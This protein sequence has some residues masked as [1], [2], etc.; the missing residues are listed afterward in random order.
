[1]DDIL[2]NLVVVIILLSNIRLL[3]TSRIPVMIVSVAIQGWVIGSLPLVLHW[4]R[5]QLT[6]V[7]ITL[8]TVTIKGV[9]LPRLLN[10]S[11]QQAGVIRE[12]EPFVGPTSSLLI[13][14]FLLSLSF[15]ITSTLRSSLPEG[16]SFIP[17]LALFTVFNGLFL[18]VSRK[19]AITQVI[20]YLTLENGVYAFGAALAVD[21]PFLVELGVLLDVWVGV[22]I[23]GIAIYHINREFDHIDTDKLSTLKH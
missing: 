1:M 6:L 20:G 3:N 12:E 15:W 10:R 9:I 2:L 4:E 19:K 14:L 18:I 5:F 21:H 11:M 16:L 17:V 13:G 7:F 23:M 8:I 22:F